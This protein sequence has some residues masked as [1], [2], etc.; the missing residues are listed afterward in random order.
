MKTTVFLLGPSDIEGQNITNI[1]ATNDGSFSGTAK[2]SGILSLEPFVSDDSSLQAKSTFCYLG[3]KAIRFSGQ[4]QHNVF[5]LVG[6]ADSSM[7][8]LREIQGLVDQTKPVRTFNRVQDV[9][10]TSRARLPVTLKDIPGCRVAQLS[11]VQP[12]SFAELEESCQAFGRWPLIIRA[13]GYHGG[14]HMELVEGPKQLATLRDEQWLYDGIF[15]IEYIDTKS[16]DSL[17]RKIRVIMI[18][19]VPMP[20]HCIISNQAFI[21]AGNRLD[22]MDDDDSLCQEEA[23]FLSEFE[24]RILMQHGHVFESIYQRIGLDVFGIDLAIVGDELVVFEA[25]ACMNF[26]D[27]DYGSQDRF[28]YLEPSIKQCKRAL[29]KLLMTG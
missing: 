3:L 20:R 10:K 11:A 28:R 6:D 23:L 13:R 16:A 18:D 12:G 14:T 26:L 9:V 24:Q 29:K 25:N 5:N 7:T 21:H 1:D 8:A 2:W 4:G 22:L 15:L 19:G 17:Y 27:Q